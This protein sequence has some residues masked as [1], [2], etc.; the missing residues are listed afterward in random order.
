MGYKAD[1]S[2]TERITLSNPHYWV[3]IKQCL[4]RRDLKQAEKLLTD[5]TISVGSGGIKS[6]Q[7]MP[8][9]AAYRDHM[10]TSS[11]VDWNLDGEDGTVLPISPESVQELSGEDWDKIWERVDALN[12]PAGPEERR[13]FPARDVGSDA[14]G[15]AGPAEPGPVHVEAGAVAAAGDAPGGPGPHA[16]A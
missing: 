1:Y 11:I 9:V 3:E 14:V 13:R 4:S 8:D 6:A 12:G 7:M 5:S 10:V 2:S 16:L 15:P